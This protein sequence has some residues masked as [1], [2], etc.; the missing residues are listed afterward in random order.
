MSLNFVIL[1]QLFTSLWIFFKD[2]V[3]KTLLQS[4][5]K[6]VISLPLASFIRIRFAFHT[7]QYV[8]SIMSNDQVSS[9]HETVQLHNTWMFTCW[10][11]LHPKIAIPNEAMGTVTE[12]HSFQVQLI[13]IPITL[14]F[15]VKS[16]LL[17]PK[18]I[19]F[20][21]IIFSMQQS[22]DHGPILDAW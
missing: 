21:V 11:F 9:N 17:T 22:E 12:S 10:D 16:Y 6:L 15:M 4:L 18:C 2:I 5:Q 19:I 20:V 8:K 14:F 3:L 7:I 13:Q 1:V